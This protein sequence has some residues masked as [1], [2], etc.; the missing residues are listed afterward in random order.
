MGRFKKFAALMLAMTLVCS[1]GVALTACGDDPDEGGK[2]E[3]VLATKIQ[4]SDDELSMK[5]GG[6]ETLT[7]TVNFG[8]TN[9]GVEWLTSNASVATVS[10]GVVTAVGAGEATITA[11]TVD[12]SNLTATC[13]VTV[14]ATAAER[15]VVEQTNKPAQP[16]ATISA[17]KLTFFADGT[18]EV[19]AFYAGLSAQMLFEGEYTI[20]SGVLSFPN[21]VAVNVFGV[22]GTAHVTATVAGKTI[23]VNVETVG[24]EA[25]AA[26]FTIDAAGATSLGLTLGEAVA[27]TGITCRTTEALE[28]EVNRTVDVASYFTVAPENA[29]DKSYTVTVTT[30]DEFGGVAGT[31]VTGDAVGN[32]TLTATTADGSFTATIDVKVVPLASRTR[33][34]AFDTTKVV[35]EEIS[36]G[37]SLL[38]MM[39]IGFTFKTDGT[40]V[41]SV[42]QTA[43]GGIQKEVGGFYTYEAAADGNTATV[44]ALL[45]TDMEKDSTYT[46][47]KVKTLSWTKTEDDKWT[48]TSDNVVMTEGGAA[49]P[50]VKPRPTELGTTY[51]AAE[52]VF[53]GKQGGL[54]DVTMTFKTDGTMV[55]ASGFMTLNC[56][57]SYDEATKTLK[58]VAVDYINADGS[59][60]EAATNLN[61]VT[62]SDTNGV[63]SFAN[64]NDTYTQQVA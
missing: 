3:Q 24:A 10:G 11:K 56:Y 33:P 19:D 23:I 29:T 13:K 62:V 35:T 37:G 43:F 27:V 63:M 45:H 26:V 48:F 64:G 40:Y 55:L 1:T 60:T 36:F 49:V 16:D 54:L 30:G 7:A 59:I 14:A 28:L 32:M 52:T 9:R 38:G 39:P 42:D 51:F 12:G 4:I 50:A 20:E 44:K 41:Y 25:N 57:Y 2:T 15:L 47:D 22:D 34:A 58:Y 21:D 6:E 8:A 5:I 18:Y 46:E 17:G 53:T 31:V 61:T